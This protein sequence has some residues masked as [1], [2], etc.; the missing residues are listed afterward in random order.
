VENPKLSESVF[1]HVEYTVRGEDFVGSFIISR[2][3]KE[4]LLIRD[5]LLNRW[6][7]IMIPSLPQKKFLVI[8]IKKGK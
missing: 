6:P 7:G 1:K 2:R 3:F 4:F 8:F 5:H